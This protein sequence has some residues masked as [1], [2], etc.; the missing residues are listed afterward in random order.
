MPRLHGYKERML[1][2][3]YDSVSLNEFAKDAPRT[4]LF[5]NRHIGFGALTNMQ[6]GGH[7]ASDATC[8]FYNWYARADF[9]VDTPA[10]YRDLRWASATTVTFVIG[11]MPVYQL[12]L[13]DLLMRKQGQIDQEWSGSETHDAR[14][15]GKLSDAFYGDPSQGQESAALRA[16][17]IGDVRAT[18][19]EAWMRVAAAARRELRLPTLGVVPVR[20][21]F[22]IVM[23]TDET[24]LVALIDRLG[25]DTG[26]IWV[27]LEGLQSRSVY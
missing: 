27:H 25:M 6:C 13:S 2:N 3:M 12:P 18:Q 17:G 22:E 14:L 4:R 8:Q 16:C 20:Q 5:G 24:A 10:M 19:S 23:D 9:A 21:R 11:V 1:V 15:A 7:M 26:R